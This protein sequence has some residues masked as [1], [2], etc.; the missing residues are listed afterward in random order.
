MKIKQ[1][2]TLSAALLMTLSVSAQ[3]KPTIDP[4]GILTKEDGGT[5]E[6]NHR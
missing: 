5:E 1:I 6:R 2:F 4:I 3:T